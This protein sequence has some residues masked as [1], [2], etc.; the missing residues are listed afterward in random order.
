MTVVHQCC[1]RFK[2]TVRDLDKL[3]ELGP[4]LSC[5]SH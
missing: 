3:A 1:G 4:T 2:V 5:V